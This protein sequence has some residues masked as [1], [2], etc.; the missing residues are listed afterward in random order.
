LPGNGIIYVATGRKFVD[1]ALES[2]RYLREVEPSESLTLI[3]DA[4]HA[5]N[6]GSESES[7]RFDVRPLPAPQFSF[8]DKVD[9]IG[10]SPYAKTIFLDSDTIPIRPFAEDMYRALEF[11]NLLALG[12]VGLNHDWEAQLF[13]PALSQYNTGVLG[14]DRQATKEFVPEWRKSFLAEDNPKHDQSSFRA[15]VLHSN[16]RCGPLPPAF[17]FMGHGS[18]ARPRILHFTGARRS[19]HFYKS[20]SARRKLVR[21]FASSEEP[22]FFAHFA[23]ASSAHAVLSPRGGGRLS[24]WVKGTMEWFVVRWRRSLRKLM[25]AVARVQSFR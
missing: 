15:V 10:L 1:M 9:G 18:V 21:E 5:E 4:E 17:N 11:C 12:G 2:I 3:T 22:G 8:I 19:Q 14:L 25:R 13:S 23:T 24:W 6:L 16:L 7:H 20:A